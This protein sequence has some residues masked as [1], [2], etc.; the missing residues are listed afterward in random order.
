MAVGRPVITRYSRAYPEEISR[1]DVIGWVPEG[2]PISL[3]DR[4]QKWIKE[5]YRFAL[6]GKQTW[7]L[8]DSF[9]SE[10]KLRGMLKNILEKVLK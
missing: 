2:D 8:F 10:E 1:S 5:P 6:R 9:F 7:K 3:S 4:V